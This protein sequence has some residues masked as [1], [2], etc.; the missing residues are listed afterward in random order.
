LQCIHVTCHLCPSFLLFVAFTG[1]YPF[2]A[3][4]ATD[5]AE[6]LDKL[7]RMTNRWARAL[8]WRAANAITYWSRQSRRHT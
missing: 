5:F 8:E 3:L 6:R 7:E 2:K 1:G 4:E